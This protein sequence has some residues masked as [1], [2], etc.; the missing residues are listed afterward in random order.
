MDAALALGRV[1]LVAMFVVSG[2][3]KLNDLSA[4]AA[5][6]ASKGLPF[7]ELLAFGAGLSETCGGL[8]IVFGYR[9]RLAAMV[10][11]VFTAAATVLVHDFW[12]LADVERINELAHAWKNLALIGGLIVLAGAG[13]GRW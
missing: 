11:I 13:P 3:G 5:F 4:T 10:L 12:N 8:M 1:V 9:T 7:A 2:L 6:I